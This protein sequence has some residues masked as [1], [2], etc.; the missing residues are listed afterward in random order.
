MQEQDRE[1]MEQWLTQNVERVSEELL[2]NKEMMCHKLREIQA[3]IDNKNTPPRDKMQAI[4]LYLAIS[5][6]LVTFTEWGMSKDMHR[7]KPDEGPKER[8]HVI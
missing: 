1:I 2:I 8:Y 4:E 6:K 3:I 7:A 5:E